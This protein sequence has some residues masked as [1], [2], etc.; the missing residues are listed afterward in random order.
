MASYPVMAD[1]SERAAPDSVSFL[2][3]LYLAIAACGAEWFHCGEQTA[4][5]K[6]NKS[7][8]DFLSKLNSM[9][10]TIKVRLR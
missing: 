9:G 10:K 4:N 5:N 7:C 6:F 8:I 3:F 2:T 1:Y